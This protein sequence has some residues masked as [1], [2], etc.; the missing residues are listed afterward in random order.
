MSRNR[1]S[2][3]PSALQIWWA[4]PALPVPRCPFAHRHHPPQL[5]PH[6]PIV[7]GKGQAHPV[8]C[9]MA[10]HG[11]CISKLLP[12]GPK[13]IR[14]QCYSSQ[15]WVRSTREG[16]IEPAFWGLGKVFGSTL[17]SRARLEVFQQAC[18]WACSA[19]EMFRNSVTGGRQACTHPTR[20][21]SVKKT[22]DSMQAPTP[23][24][25]LSLTSRSAGELRKLPSWM[26]E[27]EGWALYP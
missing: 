7:T 4:A 10:L 13:T 15:V 22:V 20:P 11:G 8:M 27:S 3:R 23:Y 9:A 14:L 1:P 18:M 26:V 5:P 16:G 19:R 25:R 21:T 6:C 17:Q 2:L 12:Q 24:V